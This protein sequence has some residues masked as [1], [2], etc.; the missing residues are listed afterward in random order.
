MKATLRAGDK[1]KTDNLALVLNVASL[2]TKK[3]YPVSEHLSLCLV[4]K[5]WTV[6]F[7]KY[8]IKFTHRI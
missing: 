7:Y 1:Q 5:K 3:L 2:V 8:S 6:L 4:L